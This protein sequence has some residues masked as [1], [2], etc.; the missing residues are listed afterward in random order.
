M[1]VYVADSRVGYWLSLTSQTSD[2]VS[3]KSLFLLSNVFVARRSVTRDRWTAHLG[4]S[5]T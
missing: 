1:K 2:K 4:R 5:I 3:G